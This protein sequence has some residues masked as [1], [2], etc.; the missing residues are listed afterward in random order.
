MSTLLDFS[1][2]VAVGARTKTLSGGQL[3][4]AAIS[5][6]PILIKVNPGATCSLS[7]AE[8]GDVGIRILPDQDC[9]LSLSGGNIAELQIMRVLIQQPYD[10]NCQVTWP[11][12][13]IWPDGAPFVDSRMGAVCCVEIMWDG[14]SLYYGRRIFG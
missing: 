3:V 11:S 13:V 10:G 9:V 6:T 14:A 7:F 5:G 2:G 4:D 8:Y 12:N 1:A